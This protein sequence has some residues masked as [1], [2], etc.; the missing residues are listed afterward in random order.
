MYFFFFFLFFAASRRINP[1]PTK[2]ERT[3]RAPLGRTIA[4]KDDGRLRNKPQPTLGKFCEISTKF[5]GILWNVREISRNVIRFPWNFANFSLK[6]GKNSL[7][8]TA[9]LRTPRPS[10][11]APRPRPP[12]GRSARAYFKEIFKTLAEMHCI[13]RN[14]CRIAMYFREILRKFAEFCEIFVYYH[15]ML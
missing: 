2:E 13:L 7:K 10:C 6:F 14:F 9:I 12:R 15:E 1:S 11:P 8:Y 5:R 3:Y 4:E